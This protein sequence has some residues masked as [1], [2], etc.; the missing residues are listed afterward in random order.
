[1]VKDGVVEA[2]DGT[3]VPMR[4]NTFCLHSDTPGAGEMAKAVVAALRAENIA[5]KPTTE[6]V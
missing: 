3:M 5:I 1:M 2:E 4:A 6:I